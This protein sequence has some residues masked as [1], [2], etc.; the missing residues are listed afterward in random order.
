MDQPQEDH[1]HQNHA[2]EDVGMDAILRASRVFIAVV[3]K[4]IADIEDL[5]SYPQWRILVIIATR[6]PQTHRAIAADLGV[7]PSN[8]TRAVNKLEAAGLVRREEDPQDRRFHRLQLTDGGQAL[9]SRVM[10]QRRHALNEVTSR[11]N[12]EDR[13]HLAAAMSAFA[14]AAGETPDEA[15]SAALGLS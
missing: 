15:M 9:V 4:S 3:A 12:D 5:V 11:M 2:D 10:A 13:L 8:A 7:H 1:A 14:E 6:G